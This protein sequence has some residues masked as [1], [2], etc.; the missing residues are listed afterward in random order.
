MAATA[1]ATA[2]GRDFLP[3][4]MTAPQARTQIIGTCVGQ[5]HAGQAA[6]VPGDGAVA[7][8]GVEEGEAGGRCHAAS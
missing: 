8:R 6:L 4:R 2:L 1:V 5:L 7:K 3:L